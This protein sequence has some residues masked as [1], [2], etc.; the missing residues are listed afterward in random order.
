MCIRD[1][2]DKIQTVS[3]MSQAN[4]SKLKEIETHTIVIEN[5]IEETTKDHSGDVS[6][7]EEVIQEEMNQLRG[8]SVSYT[9]LSR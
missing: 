6:H 2:D 3:S 7:M 8:E 1:R 9:H 5:R 4:T